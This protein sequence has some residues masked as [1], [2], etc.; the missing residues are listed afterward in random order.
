MATASSLR[1]TRSTVYRDGH[2]IATLTYAGP[3]ITVTAADGSLLGRLT[4]VGYTRGQADDGSGHYDVWTARHIAPTP[5]DT[6]LA[7]G[8]ALDAAVEFLLGL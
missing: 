2:R 3:V 8:L 1:V 6:E 4:P 7:Y 5:S